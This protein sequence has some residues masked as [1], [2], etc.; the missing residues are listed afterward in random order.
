MRE[1]KEVDEKNEAPVEYLTPP[2]SK[3]KS[4]LAFLCALVILGGCFFFLYKQMNVYFPGPMA[5]ARSLYFK[6]MHQKEAKQATAP[7]PPLAKIKVGPAAKSDAAAAGQTAVTQNA[8]LNIH[9]VLAGGSKNLVLID[10]Q[11]YQ[12]GDEVDGIKIVKISLNAIT[13][14]NNGQEEIIPVKH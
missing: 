2:K 8:P 11:V 1:G 10:D 14:I 4:F 6:L 9:G 3:V 12:E 5:K 13:V 7:L